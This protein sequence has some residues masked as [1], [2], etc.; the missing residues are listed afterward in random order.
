MSII[1]NYLWL[2]ETNI[3][4]NYTSFKTKC[5]CYK[6]ISVVFTFTGNTSLSPYILEVRWYDEYDRLL[7]TDTSPSTSL[8]SDSQYYR[9]DTKGSYAIVRF[10]TVGVVDST[11]RLALTAILLN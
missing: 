9:Y 7:V 4:I 8:S 10:T 3:A 2:A 5:D 1:P 11:Y 6:A